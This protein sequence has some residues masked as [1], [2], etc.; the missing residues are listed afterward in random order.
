M[1]INEQAVAKLEEALKNAKNT[2]FAEPVI[3]HLIKRCKE[4]E[5]LAGDVMKEG[6][7]WE[8]CFNYICNQ[9]KKQAT[10]H[11]A[12]VDDETVYGWSEVYFHLTDKEEKNVAP[13]GNVQT[14]TTADAKKAA[15]AKPVVKVEKQ[16][17]KVEAETKTEA[18]AEPKPE[19][20]EK[21]KKTEKKEPKKKGTEIDGQ[22]DM[23]ALMGM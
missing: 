10:N 1:T 14:A 15:A 3:T 6:R 20:V 23:F 7:T 5:L 19:P 16:D 11:V 12:A 13:A 18:K 22:L 8:K 2:A 17:P 9:A 21:P 4:D